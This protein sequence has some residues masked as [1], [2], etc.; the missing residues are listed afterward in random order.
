MH[1][2]SSDKAGGSQLS[3]G[4]WY[5]VIFDVGFILFQNEHK[6][7]DLEDSDE[8]YLSEQVYSLLSNLDGHGYH[9]G[10][11]SEQFSIPLFLLAQ[12]ISILTFLILA[13]I[14][15]GSIRFLF[16]KYV[17]MFLIKD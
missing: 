10:F 3:S 14:A 8:D 4:H 2:K 16:N 6:E 12:L 17:I 9:L 13:S 15:Q 7:R 5:R 1:H 11:V